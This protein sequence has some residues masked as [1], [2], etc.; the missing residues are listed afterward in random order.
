MIRK[1]IL[2]T[3]LLLLIIISVF[4]FFFIIKNKDPNK[5]PSV[6]INKELPGFELVNLFDDKEIFSKQNFND[7]KLLINFFASWCIPC[8]AEHPLLIKIKNDYKDLIIIGVD[9]KDKKKDAVE[10]LNENGNPYHYVGFDS[11]GS[12]GLEFGVFGLPETFITNRDGKIIYKHIG[13]ITKK[14]LTDEIVPL[15]K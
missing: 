1:L 5:P 7:K 4:L 8:K 3:P 6:L 11:K 9:F 10:F 2:I 13:P 14:I 12:V 15:L